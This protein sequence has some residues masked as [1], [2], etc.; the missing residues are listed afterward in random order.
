MAMQ[1]VAAL[2]WMLG[3]IGILAGSSPDRVESKL[4]GKIG[5]WSL[6]L[7][8]GW[9]GFQLLSLPDSWAGLFWGGDAELVTRISEAPGWTIAVDR[10]V[11]L[12]TLLHWSG[13]GI[14]AWGCS[15]Q[16]KG[17]FSR[18]ILLV[19][20]VGLGV[21]QSIMGIF[22]LKA[23]A[24]R[25]CGTFG[26]PDVLG[27]MLA[28]TLSVTIGLLFSYVHGHERRGSS[29]LHRLGYDWKIWRNVI[30]VAAFGIQGTA[31][32]F[33]GSRGAA[34]A[35]LVAIA[36][37]MTWMGREKPEYRSRLL[38]AGV[39]LVVLM[40]IFGLQGRRDNVMERTFGESGEF[41]QAKES[42][43]DIW[44]SVATLC[45][46]FPWGTGPGGTALVLPMFQTGAYGRFRLDYAHNDSLQ[47][48]G[49]LGWIG[50]G[51]LVCGLG[52][53]LRRGARGC[54]KNIEGGGESPWR[55][56][57]AWVAVVAALFHAQVEFNL[58]G[59][60]GIQVVFAILLGLLWGTHSGRKE[61]VEKPM[62]ISIQKRVG[63][64][65]LLLPICALAVFL[66]L[67]AALAWR[68]H[69]G[70]AE[71]M[72]FSVDDKFW[73]QRPA[74]KPEE[75]LSMLGKATELAPHFSK[76]HGTAAEAQLVWQD[77]RI[78]EAARSILISSG[79][80]VPAEWSMDSLLPAQE[81]AV[82]LAGVALRVEEKNM[83]QAALKEAD[84]AV[85]LAPWDAMARVTRSKVLFR[86]RSQNGWD[87]DAGIRARNDLE[88]ATSLYPQDAGVLADACVALSLGECDPQSLENLLSWG[89]RALEIDP[90]LGPIVLRAWRMAQIPV[91]RLLELPKLPIS[92][93]WNLYANLQKQNRD[94]EAVACLGVLE[95]CIGKEKPPESSTLWNTALWEHWNGQQTQYRLR[96]A[97]ERI[98]RSLQTGNVEDLQELLPTRAKLRRE[99]FQEEWNRLNGGET[100]SE[101]LRRLRLREWELKNGLLP[102]WLLEFQ[103]SELESG[104]TAR[105]LQEPMMEVILLDG[106]S[107]EML[108]R[109][110]MN[111]SSLSDALCL[112]HVVDAKNAESTGKTIEAL[113]SLNA[114]LNCEKIPRRF[115]HRVELWRAKLLEKEGHLKD[116][117]EAL[118]KASLACPSDPDVV[119]AMERLGCDP[120]KDWKDAGPNLDIGFRGERIL[121]RSVYLEPD[122]D[123]REGISVHSVWRLRGGLPPDLQ[124]EVRIRGQ[125]GKILMKKN[126]VL[127]QEADAA[128]NR[129]NPIPGSL[130][131]C[132]VP[133]SP[134]AEEGERVEISLVSENKRLISDEG[135]SVLELNLNK[136]PHIP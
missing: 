10:F 100:S 115:L 83:L 69:E 97:A 133:L 127:D 93:L 6:V 15:R 37:L 63:M 21:F 18:S 121:L 114:L 72:G 64:G 41:H 122:S 4:E 33:T 3:V 61:S 25:I 56:R 42:R 39:V 101:V 49:D 48:L 76:I 96:I 125:D 107:A 57:G 129:G 68:L 16:V 24:G 113:A 135:I 40:V 30:L 90:A 80:D 22:I 84:A 116:A 102:E 77:R 62:E 13:L 128:F 47:F 94:E 89:R 117:V 119:E 35:T 36:I 111:P 81:A 104:M 123:G 5:R 106:V 118:Q 112:K 23:P 2:A 91:A 12:H 1:G 66:S 20:L 28:M 7:L 38:A 14:L 29:I 60:P 74:V 134:M 110:T 53:V 131:T 34:F 58:S 98:M 92:F 59:R 54:R 17:P 71:A 73:F 130:W 43:V 65:V 26:S 11:S 45:K 86:G 120:R 136:L 32:Y 50:F 27:G 126:T 79:E 52:L 75:V 44:Q 109:L 132:R 9:C 46:R 82:R 88:I 99:R 78:Q 103:L 8:L 95:K 19:G 105:W 55:M 70:A 31:L 85:R 87:A 124:I 51:A 67:R 108:K